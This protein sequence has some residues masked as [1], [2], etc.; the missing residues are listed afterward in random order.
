MFAEF[1]LS[2]P[3]RMPEFAR[4][5]LDAGILRVR[6][7]QFG[8]KPRPHVFEMLLNGAQGFPPSCC[9]DI[10]RRFVVSVNINAPLIRAECVVCRSVFNPK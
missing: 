8:I 2:R 4:C 6:E 10:F 7:L 9:S 3:Y 5:I 1:D